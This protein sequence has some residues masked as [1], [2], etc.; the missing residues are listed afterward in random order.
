[1]GIF[2]NLRL[3]RKLL[4]AMAPLALMVVVAGVYSSFE[5]NT[6][7]TRYSALI[8]NQVEALRNV[9]EARAHTNRFGLFLYELIDETDPDRR[10]V[11]DGELDK[12]RTEYHTGMAE[13]LKASPERADKI[14]AASAAFDQAEADARPVR[15]AA[16]AG[17][18]VKAS[19]LMRGGVSQKLQQARQAT[20]EIMGDLQKYIDQRSDDLTR[21][22]HH[23]ILITWLVIGFGLLASWAT[24]FYIVETKVVNEL[25]SLR[26][27]IENL[28]GGQLDQNVPYLDRK[29]EIG[30]IGRALRTLQLGARER[31]TQGWVKAEVGATLEALQSTQD[32]PEFG[33]ALLSRLSQSIPIIYGAFYVAD[34]N[35]KHFERAYAF[36]NTDSAGLKEFALGEGLAGQAAVERRMLEVKAGD[37]VR[38]SAG[39]GTLTVGKILFIPVV[40]KSETTGLIELATNA[41]LSERQRALLDSLLPSI[42]LSAEILSGNLATKKLL[43]QTQAQAQ[44][45][46]SSERQL[47]TRKE[48]LESINQ[49]LEAS[50]EELRRA[51]EVAEEATKIK[52]DF[53]A[54]MSHEIRTPMNAIIGMSHL[55]LKTD[56]NPRQRDYVRKIQL[57]GQHLL[58]IINDILDFSKIEAGK[59][60]VENIDFDLEKVLENVSN[61]ISEKASAKGLELI[62]NIE[63]AVPMQLKGDPLRLGQ[64]LINFCNNAVKFTESG[65]IIVCAR[66]QEKDQEGQLVY[67][68]V[69]DSGI[70]LTK[71][72]MGRLFEAFEQADT[73][74]T[75]QHGGTG[76]GLAISKRL[77]NLMGGDVGVESE[78]G[79]GSTFWFT[80][81]LGN[82]ATARR[83]D[84]TPDLRGRRVLIID[85]NPQ[86]RA[87]LSS[88]LISMT[89]EADEAP[90]GLEGIEMVR[91]AAEINKPYEIVFV[92]WQMP[93]LDGFETGKR[94]RAL[95]NLAVRPQLVMV[96]A[97]GREEVLKQA[98]ENS[99]ANILIKPVTASMLFDSAVEALG[100]S[101][102]KSYE[103]PSSSP[104]IELERI[105]G[106]RVLLVEDNELNREVALGLLEDAHLSIDIAE[107]GQVAVEKITKHNYDLVLMDMQMPV[108]DGLAATRAIRLKLQFQTLPIIAMTANVMESDREKCT[109]AGMNDHLAK[110]IDPEALFACLLRWI[111]PRAATAAVADVGKTLTPTRTEPHSVQPSETAAFE[112]A[113]VDTKSALRRTGGNPKRYEMLLRKFAESTAVEEIRDALAKGDTVTAA[114]AAHSLKGAAANLGATAVAEAAAK[115]EREIQTGKTGPPAL[116]AMAASLRTTVL[117]IQSAFPNEAATGGVPSA[118]IDP[119]SVAA[120]LRRLKKLLASDD[121]EAADFILDAQPELAKVLTGSE[122][123][124]LSTLVSNFDFNGALKCVSEIAARLTLPLE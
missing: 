121:G 100:G 62:F 75:R 77:A 114:R 43:D 37:Q 99:F 96:T 48:E 35:G 93:G 98:E 6:I 67:F 11:I 112:I 118:P 85:D 115:V 59:L 56:L 36:A 18:N 123:T 94:I 55:T 64:I 95:P 31:E 8:D 71:E 19:N 90:S 25:L 29:N 17:N 69:S 97:Y 66:V 84:V 83:H 117:A 58:G 4:I 57:S 78:V 10:Q 27:S 46:A 124:A 52:S 122:I 91:H 106:S 86:A 73:S 53:L 22:T 79:K 38:I 51:K 28:A 116:D 50:G 3:R 61:L 103:S 47:S 102:S 40:N 49:A 81:R 26:G 32:Y 45:L 60:S 41:A 2:T 34:E 80:A 54:N 13:A 109:D 1:V 105:R 14:N 89:F 39:M 63:S 76:L 12:L 104:T 20:I 87:V 72:Q 101:N 15:A 82:G 120:P 21:N 7:D 88:M 107:N 42:A 111:K 68:S 110:P 70:G 74:T 23:A 9:G 33:K 65:E 24:A 5:S 30:E 44:S 16:L 92:D 108:M 119:S 113:G